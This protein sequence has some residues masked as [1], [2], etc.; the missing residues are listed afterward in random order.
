MSHLAA[1]LARGIEFNALVARATSL[2]ARAISLDARGTCSVEAMPQLAALLV[3]GTEFTTLVARGKFSVEAMSKFSALVKCGTE[4]TTL[5]AHGTLSVE[6]M[7]QFSALVACGAELTTLVARGTLSVEGALA[8]SKSVIVGSYADAG[9]AAVG[10]IEH[11]ER[12]S[13]HSSYRAAL[14]SGAGFGGKVPGASRP[15]SRLGVLLH[16]EAKT[17]SLGGIV[18]KSQHVVTNDNEAKATPTGGVV[19]GALHS[20]SQNV[21]TGALRSKSQNVATGDRSVSFMGDADLVLDAGVELLTTALMGGRGEPARDRGALC[22]DHHRGYGMTSR[23]RGRG[24]M[25]RGRGK[26][27][28]RFAMLQDS[29]HDYLATVYSD[30]GGNGKPSATLRPVKSDKTSVRSLPK[31]APAQPAQAP[32]LNLN[33]NSDDGFGTMTIPID[34]DLN[35]AK[36]NTAE[37]ELACAATCADLRIK[38]D[39]KA[40][41]DWDSVHYRDLIENSVPVPKQKAEVPRAMLSCTSDCGFCV[42]PGEVKKVMLQATQHRRI[43]GNTDLVFAPDD[44]ERFEY[45]LVEGIE[46][47]A[48]DNPAMGML[49]RTTN[50]GFVGVQVTN[51]TMM[52]VAF[53]SGDDLFMLRY[54]AD[55]YVDSSSVPDSIWDEMSSNEQDIVNDHRLINGGSRRTCRKSG[56][57]DVI[58]DIVGRSALLTGLRGG[59]ELGDEIEHTPR[60]MSDK[61][62]D[63]SKH[64]ASLCDTGRS[65]KA[66][67]VTSNPKTEFIAA[68]VPSSCESD[69]DAVQPTR[70]DPMA[71]ELDRHLAGDAVPTDNSC[72]QTSPTAADSR[73]GVSEEGP[74]HGYKVAVTLTAPDKVSS[75]NLAGSEASAASRECGVDSKV[76]FKA[77]VGVRGETA[78]D[79][80]TF[81]HSV[82][83]QFDHRRWQKLGHQQTRRHWQ[84][85]DRQFEIEALIAARKRESWLSLHKVEKNIEGVRAMPELSRRT[86]NV[87]M[88][89]NVPYLDVIGYE[90]EASISNK[91]GH[92]VGPRS[93]MIECTMTCSKDVTVGSRVNLKV[94]EEMLLCA[95]SCAAIGQRC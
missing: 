21:V 53:E 10:S 30:D 58:D 52:T 7:P 64:H 74:R 11:D 78:S 89:A 18:S 17:A 71:L 80:T 23:G 33:P 62:T 5:V 45:S 29:S 38:Q 47:V 56:S 19:M 14:S 68:T 84:A 36:V 3:R 85:K 44:D 57:G 35:F 15:E 42:A 73:G 91:P 92:D 51:T 22:S 27:V 1:L 65:T 67:N 87:A 46:L 9:A 6:A 31:P 41:L 4:L 83:E 40:Q 60:S 55:R 37:S 20:K 49:L 24:M 13:R 94:W 72:A 50:D 61:E 32:K 12:P 39:D 86:S 79:T 75:E 66:L 77:R 43:I 25:L 82:D 81:T 70:A 54:A 90:Y 69:G 59:V 76:S 95:V 28:E 26:D 48:T 88:V 8:E 93:M 63:P 2:I 34:W 16:A